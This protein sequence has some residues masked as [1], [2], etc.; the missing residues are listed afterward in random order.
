MLILQYRSIDGTWMDEVG[1]VIDQ[2]LTAQA[3]FESI[4]ALRGPEWSA[5][6]RMVMRTDKVVWP[7]EIDPA[8]QFGG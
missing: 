8:T 3:V 4:G 5:R 2:R 1:Y 7:V 6:H